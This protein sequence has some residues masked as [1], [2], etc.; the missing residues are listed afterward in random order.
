MAL[1]SKLKRAEAANVGDMAPDFNLTGTTGSGL[2]LSDLRGKQRAILFFYPQDCTSGCLAQLTEAG[3]VMEDFR[4]LDTQPFG[5]NEA[6]AESHQVF[7]DQLNIPFDLLVDRDF[8]VSRAYAAMKPD[9][10]R[11]ARTVVIV[12]KNG[13]IIF[14]AS[15]A[16]PAEE[17]LRELAKATDA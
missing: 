10:E 15:G 3:G 13:K 14:R 16:P 8:T 12:G 17:L 7:L 5:V 6:E 9:A 4:A 2:K 11:I 1:W